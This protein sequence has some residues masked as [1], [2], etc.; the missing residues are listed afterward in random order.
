VEVVALLVQIWRL[1]SD[2]RNSMYNTHPELAKE[3]QG[4]AN[5]SIA[6]THKK[7]DWKC[8]TCEHEWKTR[9]KNR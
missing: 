2:G 1:H 7:L 3:Y 6:G 8:I 9:G 4:D 5:L